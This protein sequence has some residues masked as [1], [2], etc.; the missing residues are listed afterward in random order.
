MKRM[1]FPPSLP[2]PWGGC[3]NHLKG[4][5]HW[6]KVFPSLPLMI[7]FTFQFLLKGRELFYL[8]TFCTPMFQW[9]HHFSTY[10]TV[11]GTFWVIRQYQFAYS[12]ANINLHYLWAN[13][14]LHIYEQISI[15]IFMSKSVMLLRDQ[16]QL[17]GWFMHRIWP[18]SLSFQNY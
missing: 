14:N 15:C 9:W 4:N 1:G 17:Y 8:K 16:L 18:N 13:I 12:W 7:R 3:P 5:V 11:F 2:S 10:Y 6:E